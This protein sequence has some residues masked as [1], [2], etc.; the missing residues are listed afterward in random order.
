MTN[1]PPRFI[2]R[3]CWKVISPVTIFVVL[4]MSIRTMSE[5]TPQYTIWDGKQVTI[6]IAIFFF[7]KRK[8]KINHVFF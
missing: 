3:W 5:T 8:K 6:F 7:R 2:W 4:S 1:K